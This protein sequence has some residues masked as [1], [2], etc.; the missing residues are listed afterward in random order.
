M[1]VVVSQSYWQSL[2]LVLGILESSVSLAA[3]ERKQQGQHCQVFASVVLELDL[4][5]RREA[6]EY[7]YD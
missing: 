7:V 6:C 3:P 4:Q 5:L 1:V 2:L